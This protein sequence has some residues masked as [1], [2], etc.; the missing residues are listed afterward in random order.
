MSDI[1]DRQHYK[2]G[3][4]KSKEV[5]AALEELLGGQRQRRVSSQGAH[6]H[7]ADSG[8]EPHGCM[9]LQQHL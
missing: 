1:A 6:V 5:T 8:L 7:S 3:Q 9:K 2:P 4:N